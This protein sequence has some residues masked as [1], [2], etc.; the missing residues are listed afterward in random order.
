MVT[1]TTMDDLH[2]REAV[3]TDEPFLRQMLAIAA[4]WRNAEA[5]PLSDPLPEPLAS[6]VRGFG[7]PTDFGTVA[8]TEDRD[9][10]AAWCR[11]F[12][13]EDPGYGYVGPD[14]P[15]VA[16]AV[17]AGLRGVGIGAHLMAA[18][19]AQARRREF[20]AV[21]LSVAPDNPAAALYRRFGFENARV[22]HDA[23]TMV[24]RL[25]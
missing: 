12:P 4:D 19:L 25:R 22:E 7:G 21:S 23:Q 14:V 9:I 11:L 17:I 1:P 13:P 16:I 3:S 2:V 8:S 24:R 15:E 6:Y 18:V 5:S 20:P 10:G